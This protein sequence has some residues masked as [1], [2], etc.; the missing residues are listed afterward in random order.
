IMA[1]KQVTEISL[2]KKFGYRIIVGFRRS[3]N[4]SFELRVT[5]I[6]SSLV[7]KRDLGPNRYSLQKEKVKLSDIRISFGY[8]LPLLRM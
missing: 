5:D 6:T 7:Y 4:W 8:I 3:Q 1:L 2:D